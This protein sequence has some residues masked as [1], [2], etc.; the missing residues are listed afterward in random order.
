MS[1]LYG[2]NF[3]ADVTRYGNIHV[4]SLNVDCI[5]EKL[6]SESGILDQS[7]EFMYQVLFF[8]NVFNGRFHESTFLREVEKLRD[9]YLSR[10][11][12][13]A[14]YSDDKLNELYFDAPEQKMI[15]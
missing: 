2:A 3:F 6:I 11:E 5:D 14:T 12:D 9:E 1:V 4:F 10:E 8:P 7:M 15:S 13:K